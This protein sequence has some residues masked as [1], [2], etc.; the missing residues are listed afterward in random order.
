MQQVARRSPCL[1]R[2]CHS[3]VTHSPMEKTA[4]LC[5]GGSQLI[6]IKKI[7]EKNE[8]G[9]TCHLYTPSLQKEEVDVW[10]FCFRNKD[11]RFLTKFFTGGFKNAFPFFQ[12]RWNSVSY[13]SRM[14]VLFSF[15]ANS[16]K[17]QLGT[18]FN[19]LIISGLLSDPDNQTKTTIVLFQLPEEGFH[20]CLEVLNIR[21]RLAAVSVLSYS[22]EMCECLRST[23]VHA[24]TPLTN[25][26]E[27]ERL[28][29][30]YIKVSVTIMEG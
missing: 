8:N 19:S 14:M 26:E 27:K 21:S 17:N 4:G 9:C 18:A 12:A 28:L 13:F 10:R 3:N 7:A 15:S 1:H 5:I 29:A 24:C 20:F 2:T 16:L 22:I 23:V 6:L 11:H 25:S 30:V